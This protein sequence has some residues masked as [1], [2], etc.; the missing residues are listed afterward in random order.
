MPSC[1]PFF[2]RWAALLET[3]GLTKRDLYAY[4]GVLQ[5]VRAFIPGLTAHLHSVYQWTKSVLWD[6]ACNWTPEAPLHF[7]FQAEMEWNK[8]WKL[9]VDASAEGYGCMFFKEG[10]FELGLSKLRTDTAWKQLVGIY[11]EVCAA[12][13]ALDKWPNLTSCYSQAKSRARYNKKR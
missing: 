7:P 3:R 5:F 12:K 2:Q 10:G 6:D 9:Y 4:A 11:C 8:P 1:S 13:W